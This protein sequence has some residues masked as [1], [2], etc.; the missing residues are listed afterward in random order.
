M[1]EEGIGVIQIAVGEGEFEGFDGAVDVVGVEVGGSGILFEELQ[2]LEQGGP[3]GPG[4]AFEDGMVVIVESDRVLDTGG[5]SRQV[6]E[7]EE[8]VVFT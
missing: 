4:A 5:M 8:A 6:G 7:S 1:G 3:L 2:G